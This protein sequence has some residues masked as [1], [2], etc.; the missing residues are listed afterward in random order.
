MLDS[1]AG[2]YTIFIVFILRLT[3]EE[4]MPN[5]IL[6][7][8]SILLWALIIIAVAALIKFAI[9]WLGK[10]PYD[11]TAN[12]LRVTFTSLIDLQLLL[13]AFYLVWTGL[14]G[15]GFPIPTGSSIWSSWLLRSCWR[16]SPVWARTREIPPATG[17]VFFSPLASVL[18]III[19]VSILPGGRWFHIAGL[20]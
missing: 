15:F 5:F 17:T 20:F 11:N 1:R 6:T 8:H 3:S 9:G 13:G 4:N 14:Q 18:V 7:L 10:N 16:T 12:R 2:K 19:G